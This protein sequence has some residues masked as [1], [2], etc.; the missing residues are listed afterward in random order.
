MSV[1]SNANDTDGSITKCYSTH[2]VLWKARSRVYP[3]TPLISCCIWSAFEELVLWYIKMYVQNTIH[4][5]VLSFSAMWIILIA[6]CFRCSLL[7]SNDLSG[8]SAGMYKQC[9]LRATVHSHIYQIIKKWFHYLI[10]FTVNHT[11]QGTLV[12]LHMAS[13][14]YLLVGLE[15][16]LG[17]RFQATA[18]WWE[19]PHKR[20]LGWSPSHTVASYTK[21]NYGDVE[22]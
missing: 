10:T 15:R 14:S 11:H 19:L 7:F 1:S 21:H 12:S 5:W 9:L 16:M 2:T 22:H 4:N 8:G 6:V 20:S 3:R 18:L 17:L 13:I